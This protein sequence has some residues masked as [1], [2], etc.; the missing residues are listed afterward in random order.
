MMNSNTELIH[1]RVIGNNLSS[2]ARWNATRKRTARLRCSRS[3]LLYSGRFS[4]ERGKSTT[5]TV[6]RH[7]V[8]SEYR[9]NKWFYHQLIWF[10]LSEINQ[11]QFPGAKITSSNCLFSKFRRIQNSKRKLKIQTFKRL[12]ASECFAFMLNKPRVWLLQTVKNA[13]SPKFTYLNRFQ[14]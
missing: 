10:V 11:P 3:H 5:T 4:E 2:S 13:Q 14:I 9:S 6:C 12:Q 7:T 8:Y 1:F